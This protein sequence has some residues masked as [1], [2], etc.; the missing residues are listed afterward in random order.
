MIVKQSLT[1]GCLV[2]AVR[3]D[4]IVGFADPTV[5]ESFGLPQAYS[6]P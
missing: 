4:S 2:V 6:Q 5:F 1:G 3:G